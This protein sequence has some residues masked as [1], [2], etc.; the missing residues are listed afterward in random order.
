MNGNVPPEIL[1]AAIQA[2]LARNAYAR[3]IPVPNKPG[4]SYG[5]GPGPQR[6]TPGPAYWRNVPGVGV[7]PQAIPAGMSPDVPRIPGPPFD[8]AEIPI[9]PYQ[10]IGPYI[11]PSMRHYEPLLGSANLQLMA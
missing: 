9:L 3:N 6:E 11:F 10:Q 7:V 8:P 4:V 5:Y 1:A 2:Y